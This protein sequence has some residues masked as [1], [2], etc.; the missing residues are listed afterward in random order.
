VAVISLEVLDTGS[1][2]LAGEGSCRSKTS[3]GKCKCIAIVDK[4]CTINLG[5]DRN[6]SIYGAVGARSAFREDD[7]GWVSARTIR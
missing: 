4:E 5:R 1:V 6:L 2:E 3:K 7:S